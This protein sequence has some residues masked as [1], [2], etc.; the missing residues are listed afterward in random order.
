MS[1][2]RV[3][4]REL[5][6]IG[7]WNQAA[8]KLVFWRRLSL[9]SDILLCCMVALLST[10]STRMIGRGWGRCGLRLAART[11]GR[12]CGARGGSSICGVAILCI[13]TFQPVWE[14]A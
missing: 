10:G 9:F 1:V 5:Y 4:G 14:E 7:M 8:L 11:G 6:C 13:V 3:F 2:Y 12:N